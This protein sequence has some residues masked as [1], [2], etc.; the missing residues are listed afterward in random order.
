MN[1]KLS[2]TIQS[3][4]EEAIGDIDGTVIDIETIGD[5]DKRY[6]GDSR[7]YRNLKQVI[8]GYIDS[9]RLCVYCANGTEG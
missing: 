8:L 4:E 6:K 5:F 1:I 3:L 2:P 9:E 7:E